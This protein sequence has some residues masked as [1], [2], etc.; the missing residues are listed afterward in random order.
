VQ[1]FGPAIKS[2]VEESRFPAPARLGL[3]PHVEPNDASTVKKP[4]VATRSE[5]LA[6]HA[7]NVAEGP[8]AA[9]T[10]F[11]TCINLRGVCEFMEQLAETTICL[12]ASRANGSRP[13]KRLVHPAGERR[14]GQRSH[15]T[16]IV[17]RRVLLDLGLSPRGKALIEPRR[18]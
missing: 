12:A 2:P 9:D 13:S 15:A 17:G 3:G 1:G 8:P 16:G 14:Y 18:R 7:G 5:R 6:K 4:S 11:S 10:G